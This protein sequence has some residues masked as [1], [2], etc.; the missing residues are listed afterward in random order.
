MIKIKYN[1][2][3]STDTEKSKM[4]YKKTNTIEHLMLISKLMLNIKENDENF[5]EKETF[6]MIKELMKIREEEK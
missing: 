1:F 6:K 4:I 2:D 5:N 3:F